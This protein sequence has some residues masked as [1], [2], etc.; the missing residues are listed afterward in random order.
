MIIMLAFSSVSFAEGG[1]R[2]AVDPWSFGL[3]ADTQWTVSEDPEGTN[4]HDAEEL[5][6]CVLPGRV[7]T[8]N[9]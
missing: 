7:R 4:L 9:V 1:G 8:Q 3:M 2:Y 6:G 5:P